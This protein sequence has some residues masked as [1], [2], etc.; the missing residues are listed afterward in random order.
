MIELILYV[1]AGIVAAGVF[2]TM[3]Y[4]TQDCI[5]GEDLI[6]ALLLIPFWWLG[7]AL[8]IFLCLKEFFS[9]ERII[10]RKKQK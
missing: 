5:T 9:P 4:K 2:L 6:P 8:A 10:L 1:V 7:G 3:T